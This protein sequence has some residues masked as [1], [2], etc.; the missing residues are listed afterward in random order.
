MWFPCSLHQTM[1][2]AGNMHHVLQSQAATVHPSWLPALMRQGAG[3][4]LAS[5]PGTTQASVKQTRR[6]SF[7]TPA[8]QHRLHWA[9]QA[10][11]WPAWKILKRVCGQVTAGITTFIKAELDRRIHL[12]RPGW[13]LGRA[14]H[15][16]GR[17]GGELNIVWI[18]TLTAQ[19]HDSPIQHRQ[20]HCGIRK[21]CDGSYPLWSL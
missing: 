20:G 12:S 17:D 19:D 7:W 6:L 13:N 15:F 1:A 2:A 10:F 21:N 8:I 14:E 11:P 9:G 3:L 5:L 16:L 4:L 18:R